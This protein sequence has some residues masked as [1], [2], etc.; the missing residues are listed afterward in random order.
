[1]CWVCGR[2]RANCLANFGTKQTIETMWDATLPIS[3][4]YRHI[5]TARSIPDYGLHGV[6]RVHKGGKNGMRDVVVA[7]TSKS[8]A[9]VA[10]T[11]L[12]PILNVAR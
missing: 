5:S 4:V 7:A 3:V 9:V 11:L 2:N 12:Q 8:P 1:M 10:R 6:M